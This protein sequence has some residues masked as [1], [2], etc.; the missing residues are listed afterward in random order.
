MSFRCS[1]AGLHLWL[2]AIPAECKVHFIMRKQHVF[3][4][5]LRQMFLFTL[6]GATWI[7]IKINNL[8]VDILVVVSDQAVGSILLETAVLLSF[9]SHC[10]VKTNKQFSNAFQKPLPQLPLNFLRQ[11]RAKTRSYF[12][13]WSNCCSFFF[14][15]FKVRHC[16]VAC[17]WLLHN[18]TF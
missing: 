16:V 5:T 2:A 1:P 13:L 12:F 10:H 11:P 4:I 9:W 14:F 6:C 7:N 3:V 18:H 17:V 15:F 8:P